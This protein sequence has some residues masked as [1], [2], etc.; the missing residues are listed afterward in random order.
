MLLLLTNDILLVEFQQRLVLSQRPIFIHTE[1]EFV[2]GRKLI[3]DFGLACL[4]QLDLGSILDLITVQL[5]KQ[6]FH[7]PDVSD[8]THLIPVNKRAMLLPYII[9]IFDEVLVVPRISIVVQNISVPLVIHRPEFSK[10]LYAIP[11]NGFFTIQLYLIIVIDCKFLLG[12]RQDL[13][14]LA[15]ALFKV[16]FKCRI[17]L[18]HQR[19]LPLN[20]E[21]QLTHLRWQRLHDQASPCFDVGAENQFLH[22]IDVEILV[23]IW[24]MDLFAS[25]GYVKWTK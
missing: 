8:I 20:D 7:L 9:R 23:K 2:L 13:Y 12:G 10:A 22:K 11:L 25:F 18:V 19:R 14:L 1:L 16:K 3:F 24:Q 17:H 15:S 5:R 6:Y 4:G 21:E